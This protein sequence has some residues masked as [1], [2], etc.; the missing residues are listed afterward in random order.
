MKW[1]QRKAL[2]IGSSKPSSSISFAGGGGVF[3]L[4]IPIASVSEAK[5]SKVK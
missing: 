5:Q 1:E 4:A 3:R 2:D